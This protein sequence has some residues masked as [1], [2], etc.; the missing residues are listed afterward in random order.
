ML[1]NKIKVPTDCGNRLK[2]LAGRT[3]M[4]PNILCRFALVASLE[5][6]SH[7][8]IPPADENGR[9]FNRYTLLGDC[10][11]LYEGLIVERHGEATA[12]LLVGHINRGV[13][14]LQARLR[15]ASDLLTLIP[16][17]TETCLDTPV[18]ESP[19]S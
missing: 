1:P 13:G 6:A 9:E 14:F 5:D 19:S 11:R 3:G 18:V 4:T 15:T 8:T 16:Q 7:L 2:A 12:D 17:P 10:E